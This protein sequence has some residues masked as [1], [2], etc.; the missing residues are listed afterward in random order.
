MFV[1]IFRR[2]S[3][4]WMTRWCYAVAMLWHSGKCEMFLWNLQTRWAPFFAQVADL[5][6]CDVLLNLNFTD[7]TQ[8]PATWSFLHLPSASISFPN[9]SH[10]FHLKLTKVNTQHRCIPILPSLTSVSISGC[11]DLQPTPASSA[12]WFTFTMLHTGSHQTFIKKL[13]RSDA[14]KLWPAARFRTNLWTKD[15]SV[16]ISL[17]RRWAQPPA[18][19]PQFITNVEFCIE[20]LVFIHKAWQTLNRVLQKTDSYQGDGSNVENITVMGP[21]HLLCETSIYSDC[22]TSLTVLHLA[23]SIRSKAFWGSGHQRTGRCSSEERSWSCSSLTTQSR[24][25]IPCNFLRPDRSILGLVNLLQVKTLRALNAASRGL[26]FVSFHK[27]HILNPYP[28]G[29]TTHLCL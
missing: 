17:C 8:H 12:L 18:K 27:V 19:I 26:H 2:L 28:T 9:Q 23:C 22:S 1:S 29:P 11:P 3:E 25:L 24:S 10:L 20:V 15:P 16:E 4:K 13:I 6:R 21:S 14:W 7:L 5:K